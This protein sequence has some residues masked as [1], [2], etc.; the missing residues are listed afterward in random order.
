VSGEDEMSGNL[1]RLLKAAGQKTPD[2]KPVLE[3]NPQHRIVQKLND[4]SDESRF[5][6][7][8]H[9][10]FDQALLAEGGQLDDPA[11]FV[12]RMNSLLA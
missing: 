9:L 1:E 10:L 3:I 7:W 6:D 2:F 12:R 11:S 4:E 5:S 8:T